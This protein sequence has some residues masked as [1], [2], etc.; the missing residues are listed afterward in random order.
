VNAR[1]VESGGVA[2]AEAARRFSS[3]SQVARIG[4]VDMLEPIKKIIRMILDVFGV[5]IPDWLNKLLD[6]LNNLIGNLGGL[7][8]MKEAQRATQARTLMYG[9]L[10][11][12]YRT[13]AAQ[14]LS[15]RAGQGLDGDDDDG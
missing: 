11:D 5:K 6:F 1:A 7:L 15:Q 14:R 12:I 2:I 3:G 4:I 9:H 10:R 13:D 8:G